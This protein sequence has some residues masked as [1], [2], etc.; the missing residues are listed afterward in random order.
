MQHNEETEHLALLYS[1]GELDDKKETAF[2]EH[3]KSC[4]QCQ[5]IVFLTGI[6]APALPEK[7]APQ[8]NLPILQQNASPKKHWFTLPTFA[9]RRLATVGVM[10]AFAVLMG[11]AAYEYGHLKQGAYATF[12]NDSMYSEI[13]SIETEVNDIEMSLENLF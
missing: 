9:F 8:F 11:L 3:L 4:K 6:I 10:A 13:D 5:D 7:V 2:L 1:Y 12:V